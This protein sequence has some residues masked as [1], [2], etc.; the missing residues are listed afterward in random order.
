M[1]FEMEVG[2]LFWGTVR[3]YLR[4]EQFKGAEVKWIESSGW[5]DRKF[6]INAPSY[7]ATA[8]KGWAHDISYTTQ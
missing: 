5:L 4:Q 1:I 8:L 6:T 2:R 3:D 7:V